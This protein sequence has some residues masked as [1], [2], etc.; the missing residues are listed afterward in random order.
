MK[1]ILRYLRGTSKTCLCVGTNKPM[2]VGCIDENMT[3]DVDFKKSTSGYLIT[4]LGE[5]CH[6]NQGCKNMLLCRPQ[7]LSILLSLK[8]ARSYCG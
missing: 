6:D 7:R 1:W 4:F 5:Q 3:G 8:L 2:L